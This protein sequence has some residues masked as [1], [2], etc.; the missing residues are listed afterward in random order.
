MGG[1]HPTAEDVVHVK[2]SD[3]TRL[4]PTK[5]KKTSD[6]EIKEGGDRDR[7]NIILGIKVRTGQSVSG[8]EID[9]VSMLGHANNAATVAFNTRLAGSTDPVAEQWKGFSIPDVALPEQGGSG[10]L[11]KSFGTT[12]TLEPVTL[13]KPNFQVVPI[14]IAFDEAELILGHTWVGFSLITPP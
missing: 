14:V 1:A 9:G 5:W 8:F 12:L 7:R 4:T 10:K 13:T 2:T 6:V 11:K 3:I